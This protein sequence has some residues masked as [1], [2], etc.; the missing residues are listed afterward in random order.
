MR[1]KMLVS[2]GSP[3]ENPVMVSV[4]DLSERQLAQVLIQ[5]SETRFRQLFANMAEGFCHCRVVFEESRPQDFIFLAVNEAFSTL[6]RL[7][8][9]IGKKASEVM[10]GIGQSDPELLK[11]FA[12]VALTG[13]P[14]QFEIYINAAQMWL[15]IS[16]Y[17]PGQEQVVAVFAV[18]T[19]RKRMH[20]KLLQLVE[21]FDLATRAGRLGIWDW[22]VAE[23]QLVWDELMYELYGINR[24]AFAGNYSAWAGC[25][26]PDDSHRCQNEVDQALRGERELDTEFRILLGDGSIRHLRV[27]AHTVRD[28]E[29]KPIR[30][31]GINLDV[32][33][34]KRMEESNAR[35]T[36]AVEQ[37]AET[38]V[39]T[40][41]DGTIVYVNAAFERISGYS[42]QE[43][44]G[45]NPRF[46]K[47][48]KHDKTFY[49]RMWATISSGKLWEGRLINK[50]KDGSLFHEDVGISAI[51]DATGKVLHYVAVKRDVTERLRAESLALR[52]QRLEAIGTL[53]GGLAHDLNNALAPI[54]MA[55]DLIK[56]QYP[57]ESDL[58]DIVKTSSQRATGMVR[59]LLTFAKGS[60]G[61]RVSIQPTHLVKEMRKIIYATFPKNIQLKVQFEQDLP[62]VLGDATQLDQVLLNLCVNARDAMP[63]G[64][65]LS[66]KA[67]RVE[68]DS[69]SA[70]TIPDAKPGTYVAL[71][72]SD[73]GMGM[74]QEVLD[75]I[76][77]PFF[78][79]KVPE[80]GTGLGLSTVL[81]ILKGHGGFMQVTSQPGVGS[82]FTAYL[83][84][85]E[86]AN[87]GDEASKEAETDFH[88]QGQTVLFVDDEPLLRDMAFAVLRKMNF[89]P[90]TAIDGDE[91]L[92]KALSHKHELSVI[93]TDLHMP[94][95]DGLSFSRHIRHLLPAVPIVV[96]SGRMEEEVASEFKALGKIS[97]LDKPFTERQLAETLA[98]IVG[99][100]S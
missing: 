77:E 69:L 41:A 49:Q 21:R 40:Q 22:N 98:R 14:E 80:R 37:A 31:T 38:I 97:R 72:V 1:L 63:E 96:A 70:S 36:M 50:K 79:T 2:H 73:T 61:E 44:L 16:A 90:V 76:F 59:Q 74:L 88:G 32:T 43:A 30:M 47:S 10:P 66:L 55:V 57:G 19:E 71:R 24:G 75:R 35:L 87:G 93:I 99:K 33:A 92:I 29:R 48:G 82:V 5:E 58:I 94:K 53:A 12:R 6:T 95:V 18:I 60:E 64:G 17:S 39:I 91:G 34:Q 83:P 27:C 42:R 7:K 51:R 8:G 89:K 23:D 15:E 84:A 85:V 11:R 68:L 26:H 9:V 20:E 28:S 25:L 52:S 46:L 65:T 81:G 45:Q 54:M 56:N 100:A 86:D 67:Y 4:R 78:T 3:A 62:T 13:K